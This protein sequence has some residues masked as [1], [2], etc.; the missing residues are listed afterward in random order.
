[1]QSFGWRFGWA[2][3]C[4]ELSSL[5]AAS[6]FPLCDGLAHH[7]LPG[8]FPSKIIDAA[9]PNNRATQF[10]TCKYCESHT[11]KESK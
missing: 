9:R 1:M 6:G 5:K 4:H 7:A 10:V 3:P 11:K 2:A 8:M